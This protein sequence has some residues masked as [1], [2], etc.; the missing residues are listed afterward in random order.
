M[1]L[2]G[3]L[4]PMVKL[5]FSVYAVESTA[6]ILLF[7]GIRFVIC[8]VVICLFAAI[9]DKAS[10]RPVKASLIPILLSGVFAIILHYGFTYLGLELTDSSKTALIK[11]VGALFYVCFSFLFIKEDTPTVKKIVAA[12]VGFLGIIVLNISSEGFSF[13]LGDLLILCASFCTVFSNVISKKVFVK[14]SPITSTG[15]SQLF[16]GAVLLAVGFAMGGNVHFRWDSSLL[17]IVYICIASIV[18]YCIWFGIVKN[19]ELSKLFIIKFAEPV[20]ACIFSAVILGE[21]IL[22]WQYLI[23]FA[24]ISAGIL[25]SNIRPNKKL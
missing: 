21:N 22:K 4:F 9:K 15:I 25:I 6:D 5:G 12:A 8:G 13:A 2:W 24:L 11:Q 20:F 3:S 14:V 17:I 19:G 18:S 16:G 1:L 10:Y 7:A 23:S